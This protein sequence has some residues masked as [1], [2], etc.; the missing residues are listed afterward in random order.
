[1][2]RAVIVLADDTVVRAV[3]ATGA[4][5]GRFDRMPIVAEMSEPAAAE[6]LL[7][8]CD[9]AIHTVVSSL[10]VARI[11]AFALREPGLNRV[12]E[13]LLDFRGCG[14]HIRPVGGLA[15]ASFGD[16]VFRFTNARPI[17]RVRPDGDVERNPN[18]ATR[19]RE[20]EQLIIV[21]DDA[22]AGPRPTAFAHVPPRSTAGRRSPA[23]RPEEHVVA[24]RSGSPPTPG[25]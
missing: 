16:C 12:V 20:D 1:M 10:S 15:G 24:F 13:E 7:R 18:P 14:V 5:L 23:V 25:S 2:T 8:A 19:L 22:S 21:A 17:G 3:L 9:G 11:T 6:S 4:E